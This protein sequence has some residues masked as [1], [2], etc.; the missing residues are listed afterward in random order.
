MYSS[1]MEGTLAA[2]VLL[3]R[4]D[5]G[6][7][8]DELARRVGVSRTY[9]SKIETGAVNSIMTDVAVAL[10]GALHV[11]IGYLL[12]LTD[13]PS[14]EPGTPLQAT[15]ETL[16]FSVKDIA[17]RRTV[18]ELVAIVVELAPDDRDFVLEMAERIWRSERREPRI[19]GS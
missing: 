15:E 19:V 10:A 4:R 13:I 12:G 8:Q 17:L 18:Q 16:T 1:V 14:D 3:S 5:L 11:N 7:N 6:I 9:I 2:R